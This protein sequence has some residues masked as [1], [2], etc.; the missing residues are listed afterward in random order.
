MRVFP[1]LLLAGFSEFAFPNTALSPIQD[2]GESLLSGF[3]NSMHGLGLGFMSPTPTLEIEV[4][5][6]PQA[7]KSPP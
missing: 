7:Q 1:L 6:T 4:P 2:V 3:G 5:V